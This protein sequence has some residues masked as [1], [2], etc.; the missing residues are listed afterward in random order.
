MKKLKSTYYFIGRLTPTE[1]CMKFNPREIHLSNGWVIDIFMDGISIWKPG[2]AEN[3]DNVRPLI[4]ETI[5]ILVTTFVLITG[6]QIKHGIHQ[7]VEAKGVKAYSNLIG[8]FMPRGW[9][10]VTPNSKNRL[11]S[12]WRKAGKNCLEIRSSINHRLA[13]MDYK[14]CISTYGDDV[15]F[16]AYRIIEDIRRAVTEH[17]P[18]GLDDKK[19]WS[20]M[21]KILETSEKM[22]RP[23]T[24]VAT[25][26]RHGDVNNAIVTKA[27][28]NK[29]HIIEIAFNVMK[30]EF[31]RKFKGL[32]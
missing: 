14:N 6:I 10:L 7:W 1:L 29:K 23:L 26:I 25:R 12:A 4:E 18:D 28:N 24:E 19:Y 31:K 27:R 3:F 32:M 13:L 8:W 30:R 5:D 17:L 9:K 16:Y 11:N 15:F 2:V 21:H 20:E 22:I